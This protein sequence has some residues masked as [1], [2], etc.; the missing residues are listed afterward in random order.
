MLKGWF[1]TIFQD[2]FKASYSSDDSDVID[3]I[4]P[5]IMAE[6]EPIL[7]RDVTVKGVKGALF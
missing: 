3:F 6:I 5:K 1:W 4:Q 7:L 2:L